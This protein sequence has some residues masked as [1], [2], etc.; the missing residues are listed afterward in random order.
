MRQQSEGDKPL[1]LSYNDNQS[2]LSPPG[3]QERPR[4]GISRP[5]EPEGLALARRHRLRPV[6]RPRLPE[7]LRPEL[8][9]RFR[10]PA[11]GE[12]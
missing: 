4:R 7:D 11:E 6:L 1:D 8:V 9:D 3:L 2:N 10:T 12:F 5:D